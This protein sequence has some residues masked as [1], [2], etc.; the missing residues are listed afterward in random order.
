M[1]CAHEALRLHPVV[2]GFPRRA[3]A[4]VELCA[5]TQLHKGDI[6]VIRSGPASVEP[7]VYG[8][9]AATF[10]PYRE[11]PAGHYPHGLAFG[12]GSHMCYG[13]PI[14]MGSEGLD[15]SLVY[16]TKILMTAGVGRDPK[17]AYPPLE[18]SRGR[19]VTDYAVGH[20]GHFHVTLPAA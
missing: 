16:L 9:D 18:E 2:A 6:A 1:R 10:N 12:T 4:D 13:M 14:V 3:D 5:H 15:G 8:D 17:Y 19:F 7:G 20:H 11:V